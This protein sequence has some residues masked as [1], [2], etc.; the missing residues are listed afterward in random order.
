M[1]PGGQAWSDAV[2]LSW[3]T[4]P[5]APELAGRKLAVSLHVAGETGPMTWHATALQTSYVTPS[6]AGLCDGVTTIPSARG[7]ASAALCARSPGDRRT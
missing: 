7:P 1:P 3:I 6:G 2:T 4:N 5:A